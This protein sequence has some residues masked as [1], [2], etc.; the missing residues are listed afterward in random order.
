MD[1]VGS[2]DR[3]RRRFGQPDV[4]DLAFLNQLLQLTNGDLDGHRRVDAVLVVEVDAVDAEPPEATLARRP[5]ICRVASDSPDVRRDAEL[6]GHLHLLLRR[7][8]ECLADED[9]VGV[10]AVGVGGVEEGDPGRDGVAEQRHHVGLGL[11]LAV[12]R[13]HAHAAQALRRDLQPLRAQL[14]RARPRWQNRRRISC[15]GHC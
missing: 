10:R 6:G 12:R 9:L 7:A 1:C 11:A 3:G 15:C 14:H 2:S 4:L 5:K 13:R 8:M